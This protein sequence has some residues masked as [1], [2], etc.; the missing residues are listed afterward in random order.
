MPQAERTAPLKRTSFG[1]LYWYAVAGEDVVPH[2]LGIGQN[3][4]NEAAEIVLAR[5]GRALHLRCIAAG[6]GEVGR[7]AARLR[8]LN[9]REA[10][11]TAATGRTQDD[12][13]IDAEKQ[14]QAENDQEADEANAAAAS[15]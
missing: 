5:R 9:L 4:G 13:W 8:Q 7:L 3:D 10:R 15:S 14:D 6:S 2:V 1:S 11:R 12:L